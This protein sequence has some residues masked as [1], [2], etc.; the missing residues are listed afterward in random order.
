MLETIDVPFEGGMAE[1][2]VVSID[3]GSLNL[4]LT[5]GHQVFSFCIE[6]QAGETLHGFIT[7]ERIKEHKIMLGQTH[8]SLIP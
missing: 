4:L 1:G 3:T 5:C 8:R 6:M 7:K 2:N